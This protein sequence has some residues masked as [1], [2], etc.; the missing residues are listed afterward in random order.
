MPGPPCTAAVGLDLLQYQNVGYYRPLLLPALTDVFGEDGP[1]QLLLQARE[2]C[3]QDN[4]TLHWEVQQYLGERRGG[5][6]GGGGGGGEV[7]AIATHPPPPPP[8]SPQK[9]SLVVQLWFSVHSLPSQ[10]GF[11]VI[12]N[13]YVACPILRLSELD[14]WVSITATSTGLCS[15]V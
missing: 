5:G 7:S 2:P 4:L 11:G 1:I 14:Y 8:S 12:F 6:G 10:E 9:G 13:T 15:F 3:V